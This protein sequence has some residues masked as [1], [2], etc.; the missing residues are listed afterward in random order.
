MK[1]QDAFWD[2]FGGNEEKDI[3]YNEVFNG[4]AESESIAEQEEQGKREPIQL[5][6]VEGLQTEELEVFSLEEFS[7]TIRMSLEKVVEHGTV[8][9]YYVDL[10]NGKIYVEMENTIYYVK[11]VCLE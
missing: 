3:C 4:E 8:S 9:T 5:E 6:K 7:E 11:G 2:S 1:W 10:E